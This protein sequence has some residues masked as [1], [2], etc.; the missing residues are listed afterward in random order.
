MKRR[1]LLLGGSALVAAAGAAWKLRLFGP[2]YAPTPYDDLLSRLDDR[3]WARK[4]GAQI[5]P[6]MPDFTPASGAARLRTLLGNGSLETAA[7]RDIAA[8]RLV[9]AAKWLVPESVT[10]MAVLAARV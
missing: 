7:M 10:L 9:E 5:L 8:G 2:H 3:E 6:A 1:T 4:F